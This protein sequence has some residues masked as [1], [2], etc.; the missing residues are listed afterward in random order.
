MSIIREALNADAMKLRLHVEGKSKF[1]IGV[2]GTWTGTLTFRRSFDGVTFQSLTVTPFASGTT[3]TTATANG[4][5]E[6]NVENIKYI[7]VEFTRTTGTAIVKLS[8]AMDSSYQD[9]FLSA[10][11]I[12][13]QAEGA[14]AGSVTL[15]QTAQANRAWCLENLVASVAGPDWA[16]GTIWVAVYDGAITDTILFKTFLSQ[17][18]GS[19]G[20]SYDIPLPNVDEHDQKGI[21]GTTGN[22]MTIRLFGLASTNTGSL[23][24][25]F[26]AG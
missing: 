19:V 3:V 16:G 8:A 7:E 20:R 22:A 17:T 4:N 12:H 23:N 11:T 5:W 18:A 10:S 6:G 24:A 1:G 25:K 13:V 21:I 15:T 26:S 14:G 9:A 2:T